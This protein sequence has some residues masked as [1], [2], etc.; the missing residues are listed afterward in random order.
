MIRVEAETLTEAYSKAAEN[1]NCSVTE[2]NI[3]VLQ[4][5]KK[6][7]FGF[8]QKKAIITAEMK[9]EEN[10]SGTFNKK[11]SHNFQKDMKK[12]TPMSEEEIEKAA[13]EIEKQLQN[14][15][16]YSCF[17]LDT[18]KVEAGKNNSV[19]IN[20][21]GKDAAL[22]IGKEGY[23]YKAFSY[24]IYNWINIKYQLNIRLEIAEFLKNQEEMIKKYLT[25]VK[26]RIKQ[27][28]RGQT[29]PLD[30]VLVK[31]ALEE[32]REEFK[33]KYVSIKTNKDGDKYIIVNDFIRR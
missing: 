10:K 16:K 23:R 31:I 28:G 19:V 26:E 11:T 24:M 5:P 14:L 2:L 29:K 20:I 4:N 25:P 12:Y 7:I 22:L 17:E 3:T 32:L 8:L 1:L 18:I 21:D 27:Y 6:G 30:G 15:M 33:D 9:K 13:K